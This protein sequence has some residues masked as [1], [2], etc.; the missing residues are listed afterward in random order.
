MMEYV[1]CPYCSS[2]AKKVSGDVIYPHRKDLNGK[3]FYLCQPCG[4]YVGCHADG[5]PYGRLANSE[6]RKH[7]MMAHGLF[8]RIWK[9]GGVSRSSAYQWLAAK[10]GLNT[11]DC[12]IGMFDVDK[13]K[14][15]IQICEKEE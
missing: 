9:D 10:M 7:R 11:S 1:K 13:C 5:K 14:E 8:D 12:H 4:A 15:V 6:L 3:E 2:S